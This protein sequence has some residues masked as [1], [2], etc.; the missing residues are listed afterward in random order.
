MQIYD[1]DEYIKYVVCCNYII[2]FANITTLHR[3]SYFSLWHA[4]ILPYGYK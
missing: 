1:A 3:K 2:H 4:I